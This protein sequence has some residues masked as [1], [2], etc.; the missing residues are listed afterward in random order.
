MKINEIH[1]IDQSKFRPQDVIIYKDVEPPWRK[2]MEKLD[3]LHEEIKKLTDSIL[4]SKNKRIEIL[5]KQ[6]KGI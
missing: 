4:E 1:E 3:S 2:V 6:I 5:E